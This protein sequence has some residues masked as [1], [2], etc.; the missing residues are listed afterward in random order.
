[1]EEFQ[2]LR[3]KALQKIKIADHMLFM[4]Y[5]LVKDPKLLLAIIENIF[6]SLDYGISALLQHERL[7]KRIPPYHDTFASRFEIFRSKMIPRYGLSTN[8]VK[9]IKEVKTILSEHKKSPVEFARKDKF[10]ICSPTYSLKTIDISL[11]KKYVFET[12]VFIDN[13][14]RIVSKHEG[15][16][17]RRSE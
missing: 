15:I 12:K 8:Y 5:P 11:V 14:N 1:M 2:V 9:L 16:F 7:F 17:T 6:A 13:I 10:V 3:D 4:T